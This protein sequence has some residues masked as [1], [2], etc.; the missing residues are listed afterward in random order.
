MTCTT[1][2]TLCFQ[3]V[4]Y[5]RWLFATKPT[6]TLICGLVR[7]WSMILASPVTGLVI[8]FLLISLYQVLDSRGKKQVYVH[9]KSKPLFFRNWLWNCKLSS[10]PS[11]CMQT[12]VKL[13]IYF[14]KALKNT[15]KK[16]TIGTNAFLLSPKTIASVSKE[17][18]VF[19]LNAFKAPDDVSAEKSR[20]KR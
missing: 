4:D 8:I 15:I 7:R 5:E 3:H 6:E 20:F 19:K 2:Y 17:R 11:N 9:P 18:R 13:A 10:H 16:L 12:W 1:V 14:L